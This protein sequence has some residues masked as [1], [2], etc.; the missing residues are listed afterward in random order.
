[1]SRNVTIE[2][3]I[4]GVVRAI[5]ISLSISF[6]PALCERPTQESVTRLYIAEIGRVPDTAGLK[7]WVESSGLSLEEIAGSFFEQEELRRKYPDGT[8]TD[9]FIR[10]VY[11]NLFARSPE[12][13]GL[14]YW[15]EQL[16]SGKVKREQFILAVVN[17]AKGEDADILRNRTEAGLYFVQKGLEDSDFGEEVVSMVDS[18]SETV[19]SAKK[20]IDALSQSK[21]YPIHKEITATMF[22]AGEGADSENA[23]ISNAPSAWDKRWAT[24]YGGMDDPDDRAG[25]QPASFTPAENPFYFALPYNDIGRN[26]YRKE[27]ADSIVPWYYE[28]QDYVLNNK[29]LSVCKNRW[30][31]VRKGKKIVY[32]QWE[33]VGPFRDDDYDYVFGDSPPSNGRNNRAGLD[34]SPAAADYLELNDIAEVEWRFV[35]AKSVP[36]GPWKDKI[37]ISNVR[38]Q[39]DTGVSFYWQLQGEL[40]MDEDAKIYDVDLFD[41]SADTIQKIRWKDKIVIC[42]FSAG[43]YEDWRSDADSF[44]EEVLGNELDGWRGER[45]LDIRDSR[46]RDIMLSRLDLAVE[47]GC[48]GVEPD[49]IDGYLN[50]SGFALSA[51]D[52]LQY[53]MFIANE[54]RRRGLFVGLKN[55][56]SQAKTLEPYF[57]FALVE[58]CVEQGECDSFES[59]VNSGKAVFD[60]EYAEKYKNEEEREKLCEIAKENSYTTLVLPT[61]LDGSFVY[62]CQ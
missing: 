36:D 46:V 16:Q 37:T 50:D 25:Y 28:N 24:N 17:G 34:L 10:A 55:D 14:K 61:A 58:E 51:Q 26:G 21:L 42:Y 38:Y 44:P 39:P 11:S 18:R 60:V 45:W 57:D 6:L 22:W 23:Y 40:R 19:N 9:E 20:F 13:E 52:Q 59:F 31:R 29:I 47:K 12:R 49:N 27:D 15:R 62:Y 48:D 54:A 8:T 3:G 41:N 4:A 2:D 43:T 35:D 7:Y 56:A 53:N 1:M 32:A 33:D 30:I 5:F